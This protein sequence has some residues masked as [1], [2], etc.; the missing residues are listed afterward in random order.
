VRILLRNGVAFGAFGELAR[1]V[2][3]DVAFADFSHA[4]RKQTVSRVSALTGLSRKEVKRLSELTDGEEA[5]SQERYSRAVRVISGWMNDRR[6]QDAGGKPAELP[7]EGRRKS[8]SLLVRDYSGDVPVKAMLAILDEAG[9]VKLTKKGVRL[10]RRAYVP[11]K[12]PVDKIRILGS[13]VFELVSVIDHNLGAEPGDLLF[14]R[15]VSYD[16]IDPESLGRLRKLSSGRAQ[17]LLEVLDKHYAKHELPPADGNG[18]QVSLGI[19]YF[20]EKSSQ[21]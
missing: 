5:A 11:G 4:D 6:F 10:V 18:R 16:N 7:L 17:K 15:K 13:D 12:D 20:E 14:Q 1:K 2:Y 3:V 9:S 21:E 19:Y 8:F